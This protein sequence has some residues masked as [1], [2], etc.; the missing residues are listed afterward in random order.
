MGDNI[1]N[2]LPIFDHAELMLKK[3]ELLYEKINVLKSVEEKDKTSR[4][5]H[6]EKIKAA[7]K[8]LKEIDHL[9]DQVLNENSDRIS[10]KKNI[11]A[12]EQATQTIKTFETLLLPLCPKF[13][14]VKNLLLQKKRRTF[15]QFFF[16]RHPKVLLAYEWHSILLEIDH[17]FL[18]LKELTLPLAFQIKQQEW[19]DTLEWLKKEIEKRWNPSIYQTSFVPIIEKIQKSHEDCIECIKAFHESQMEKKEVSG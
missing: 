5:R 17:S 8:E 11:E 16:Q 13:A 2:Q 3:R 18:K 9:I 1:K 12:R 6:T 15:F 7:V 10:W 14:K 19:L 4:E